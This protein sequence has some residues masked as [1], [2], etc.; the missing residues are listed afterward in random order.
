MS[1]NQIL[2]VNGLRTYFYTY[3]GIVKAVDGIGLQVNK[4][5]TVGLVGES[6]SGKTVTAQS[7]MRVVP[8]PG[9]TIEGEIKFQGKNLLKLTESEMQHI[10]GKEIAYIPQDP[11]TTLDPVYSVGDQL[12]EVIMR[13]Q[14]VS[15]K[16]AISK[17]VE[18]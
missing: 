1:F 5:E 6:G 3:A 13:H 16:Y 2:S 10:R 8:T 17:A 11:T 7:I 4:G 12:T 9:K 15:K 18:L 14:P